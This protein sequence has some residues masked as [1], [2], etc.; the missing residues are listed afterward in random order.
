MSSKGIKPGQVIPFPNKQVDIKADKS[1]ENSE[2][3]NTLDK[4]SLADK[5]SAEQPTSLLVLK[6]SYPSN[7]TI[8]FSI[9]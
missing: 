4:A 1:V 5:K 7:R 3:Y 8:M 6:M 2:L 9:S